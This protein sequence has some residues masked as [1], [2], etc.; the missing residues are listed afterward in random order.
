LTPE[1]LY[2]QVQY[3]VEEADWASQ[4]EAIELLSE[5]RL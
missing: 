5:R 4:G 2:R 1:L 3:L